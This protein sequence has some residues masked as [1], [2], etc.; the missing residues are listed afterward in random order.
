MQS[1]SNDIKP[2]PIKDHGT[3]VILLGDDEAQ[4]TMRGISTSAFS[5]SQ[6][7]LPSKHGKDGISR[8]TTSTTFS[9]PSPE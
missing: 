6:K 1:V 5:A 9:E 2:E 4:D 3:V 8:G 7:T